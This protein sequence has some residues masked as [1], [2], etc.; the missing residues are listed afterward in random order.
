MAIHIVG[1]PISPNE[2]ISLKDL[3]SID[4]LKAE[5]RMEEMKLD[6]GWKFD[7][8]RLLVALSDD[9]YAAWST[10]IKQLLVNG[11]TNHDALDTIIGQ[12]TQ[13]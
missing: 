5:G 10:K 3:I 7:T 9:K 12:L 6:L 1:R 8:R 11:S 13:R 2:P 4:K